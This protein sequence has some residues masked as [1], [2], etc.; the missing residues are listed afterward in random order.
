VAGEHEQHKPNKPDELS[1]LQHPVQPLS[2]FIGYGRSV[3]FLIW[4]FLSTAIFTESAQS[5]DYFARKRKK[6]TIYF[7]FSFQCHAVS[8]QNL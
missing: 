7:I 2:R 3:L 6:K 5:R 4:G 8:A 1:M